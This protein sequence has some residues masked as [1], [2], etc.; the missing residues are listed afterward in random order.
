L[1]LELS[2][3]QYAVQEAEQEVLETRQA[4]C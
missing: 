4:K 3:G 2:E 1:T